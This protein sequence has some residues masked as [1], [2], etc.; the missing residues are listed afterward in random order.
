MFPHPFPTVF[1][2]VAS[3]F[4]L[5]RKVRSHKANDVCLALSC[6]FNALVPK[7]PILAIGRV[8]F[9]AAIVARSNNGT[10]TKSAIGRSQIRFCDRRFF[11]RVRFLS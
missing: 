7:R 8:E 1:E 10:P 3:L 6:F 4:L 9:P 11:H 5:A 2:N